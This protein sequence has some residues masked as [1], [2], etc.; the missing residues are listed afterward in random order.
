MY[1]IIFTAFGNVLTDFVIEKCTEAAL[2][3]A[4]DQINRIN[5]N[6]EKSKIE[7]YGVD[8]L[9]NLRFLCSQVFNLGCLVVTFCIQKDYNEMMQ[10]LIASIKPKHVLV[11]FYL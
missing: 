1:I 10:I 8:E 5:F 2:I 11:C 3:K 4:R 7:T 6:E 9:K